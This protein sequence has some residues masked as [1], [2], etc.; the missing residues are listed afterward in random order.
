[1][2]LVVFL[3]GFAVGYGAA[4]AFVS[5]AGFYW[6]GWGFPNLTPEANLR[7][8]RPMLAFMSGLSLLFAF[9]GARTH[10]AW[11]ARRLS[12]AVFGGVTAGAVSV[13]VMFALWGLL[14][15]AIAPLLGD[16]TRFLAVALTIVNLV[17]PAFASRFTL[18]FMR[19][20][21]DVL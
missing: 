8:L 9:A 16:A 2:G 11:L 21:P 12:L 14:V 4:F 20:T 19:A 13:I 7:L 6:F 17:L 5:A 1:M 18:N 3:C 15:V 10:Q